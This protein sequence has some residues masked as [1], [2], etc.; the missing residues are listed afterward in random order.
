MDDNKQSRL[1][2]NLSK[3]T[4]KFNQLL[5]ILRQYLNIFEFQN[6]NLMIWFNY[7]GKR[8]IKKFT[9]HSSASSVQ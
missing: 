8:K 3:A 1:L 2:L 4:Q 6:L 7:I 5:P 9:D